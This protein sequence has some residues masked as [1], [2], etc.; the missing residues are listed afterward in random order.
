MAVV[1]VVEPERGQIERS[2]VDVVAQDVMV[3]HS[4][5]DDM[6]HILRWYANYDYN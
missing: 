1:F 5:F 3:Q 2:Q 4:W 6:K